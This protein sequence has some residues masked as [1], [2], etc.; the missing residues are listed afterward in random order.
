MKNIFFLST[1]L[2]PTAVFA[3]STCLYN[4]NGIC[5]SGNATVTQSNGNTVIIQDG[6]QAKLK[7]ININHESKLVAL[8]SS[9]IEDLSIICTFSESIDLVAS[10]DGQRAIECS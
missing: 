3:S 10:D 8:V 6:I 7:K 2:F 1:I 9:E 4:V 5:T